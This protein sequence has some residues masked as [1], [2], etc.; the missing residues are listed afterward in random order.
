MT[1]PDLP[2]AEVVA[3][4]PPHAVPDG[5]R[6][7][8][9]SK[10]VAPTC[11]CAA[12]SDRSVLLRATLQSIDDCSA[13]ARVDAVLSPANPALASGDIVGGALPGF[14]ECGQGLDL[15]AGDDVLL[16]YT[17][18]TQDGESC[19]AYAQCID[20]QCAKQPEPA[21]D[22]GGDCFATCVED[23]RA[24][25]AAHADEARLGGQLVI[26]RYGNNL[27]F[28]YE[29]TDAAITLPKSEI[30]RLLDAIACSEWF[31]QHGTG[32]GGS[33]ADDPSRCTP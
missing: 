28:G 25:C 2:D 31:T 19:A 23:T 14:G 16:V 7:V 13:R 30:D 22:A 12:T 32:A 21:R 27:V 33:S 6:A 5:G 29:A 26:A 10:T 4:A 17:R 20:E 15:A 9:T 3:Q 18:G 8:D 11:A 24:A 1:L